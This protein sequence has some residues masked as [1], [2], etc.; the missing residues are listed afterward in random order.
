MQS[1]DPLF[2]RLLIVE[3][4][5]VDVANIAYRELGDGYLIKPIE[6]AKLVDE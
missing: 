3:D 1:D 4:E 6:K 5:D 2:L